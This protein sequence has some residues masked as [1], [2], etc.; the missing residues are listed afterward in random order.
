[1]PGRLKDGYATVTPRPQTSIWAAR[2][3]HK[4][5]TIADLLISFRVNCRRATLAI[6]R[7]S[8]I[9]PRWNRTNLLRLI[10]SPCCRYNTGPRHR[11][12]L[13]LAPFI[14][15][16]NRATRVG[17]E[18]NL[19]RVKV[20]RP[21]QQPNG[22][23]AKQSCKV[24]RA[25]L[26]LKTERPDGAELNVVQ[27]KQWVGRRSNPRLLVFSQALNRLSYRPSDATVRKKNAR[28]GGHRASI[29]MA[30]RAIRCLSF[31]A[32]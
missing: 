21:H 28:R 17:F 10:R 22:P 15:P 13:L 14:P 25:T 29:A 8:P 27:R 26:K 9:I 20:C 2:F 23:R 18:P 32:D 6:P 7:C 4:M 12:S 31:A 16:A 11:R 24:L 19:R 5:V 30:V 3:K 1:M